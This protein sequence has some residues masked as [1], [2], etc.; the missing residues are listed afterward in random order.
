MVI[1]A[2]TLYLALVKVFGT[3]M[4]RAMLKYSLVGWGV[5][6]LFPAIGLGVGGVGED[7]YVDPRT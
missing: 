7:G 6:I 5:P 2:V 4:S 1:E 3:Y